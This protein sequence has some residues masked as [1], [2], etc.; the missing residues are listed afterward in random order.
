MIQKHIL[1]IG[2]IDY[3]SLGNIQFRKR[4][5]I[6]ALVLTVEIKN[7]FN[8]KAEILLTGVTVFD[9]QLENIEGIM[10]LYPTE[11]VVAIDTPDYTHPSL[12]VRHISSAHTPLGST[13]STLPIFEMIKATL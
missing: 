2:T 7:T 3:F 5:K 10:M 4:A 1:C 9:Q 13:I 12:Q 6:R 11:I 8:Q